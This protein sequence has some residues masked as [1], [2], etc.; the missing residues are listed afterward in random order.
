MGDFS[1]QIGNRTDPMETATGKYG[2]ELRNE[3]GGTL[4]TSRKYKIMNTM[5]Q[6]KSG[7][8]RRNGVT[9]TEID[10]IL[11]NR[12]DIVR[13]VTIKLNVEVERKT[14]MTKRPPRVDC[15]T[16]KIKED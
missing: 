5:F 7:W 11:T 4:A 8:K 9:K 14:V 6:K 10:Y 12:P 1:A 15:H 16:N 2:L 13:D 3:R